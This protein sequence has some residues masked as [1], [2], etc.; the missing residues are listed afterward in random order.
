MRTPLYQY[1][2]EGREFLASRYHALLADEMGLGK[3][4][5]AIAAAEQVGARRVLVVCPASVRAQWER[6]VVEELGDDEILN[7]GF[8][9]YNLVG[10]GRLKDSEWDVLI[11]DEAH[12]LKTPDSRRT[13]AVLGPDGVARRARFKWMLTGT[14]VLNRPVE[15]YPILS[16]LCGKKLGA[17]QS[18]SAFTQRYCGA[19]WEGPGR[20]MNVRGASRVDEL[21]GVLDGF[22]LRRELDQVLPEL[23]KAI[24]TTVGVDLRREDA[25]IVDEVEREILGREAYV[26]SVME[27]YSGLG[28][29]SRL[30]RATGIAKIHGVTQF[31]RDLLETVDKVVVF[32]WH[33]EV[34][35][36]L[37]G[38]LNGVKHYGGMSDTQ[39]TEAREQFTTDP[40]CRVFVGNIKSSGTGLDGLQRVANNCVFAE[41]SWTPGEM[42]QCIGRLKRIGQERP[43]NAYVTYAPG[44]IEGAVLGSREGKRAVIDRLVRPTNLPSK[45]FDGL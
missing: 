41:N 45:L 16:T 32:A 10:D 2:K 11:C 30:M 7:W 13:L 5:Q 19:Y 28:D 40:E 39:K 38:R 15:F 43:I 27:D 14:P 12:F 4:F 34:I 21:R 24:V 23:P 1:Q 25:E 29:A 8:V 42:D 31:V 26:S 17:F 35:D 3:T 9:S 18:Y 33:R 36:A 20:G 44:T 6:V 22:I 37:A